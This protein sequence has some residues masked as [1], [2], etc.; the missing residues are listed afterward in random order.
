MLSYDV[1]ERSLII[2]FNEA[3]TT[4]SKILAAKRVVGYIS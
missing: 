3:S 2:N 1:T 4:E